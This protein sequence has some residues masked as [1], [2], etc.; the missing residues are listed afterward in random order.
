MGLTGTG[1]SEGKC[2]TEGKRGTFSVHAPRPVGVAGGFTM[3]FCELGREER[4]LGRLG[5][6]KGAE[7]GIEGRRGWNGLSSSSTAE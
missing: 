3:R 1:L 5:A 7:S 4:E 2:G 6:A